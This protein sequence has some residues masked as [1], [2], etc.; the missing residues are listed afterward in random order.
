MGRPARQRD[1]IA[2]MKYSSRRNCNIEDG[3]D[4]DDI[5]RPQ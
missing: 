5:D 1:G 4:E 3:L 2:S